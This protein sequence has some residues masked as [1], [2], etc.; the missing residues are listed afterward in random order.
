[1]TSPYSFE[2]LWPDQPCSVGLWPADQWLPGGM[3]GGG[4]GEGVMMS[5]VN[6]QMTSYLVYCHR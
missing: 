6:S 1:M 5:Q 2:T 4:E 3:G